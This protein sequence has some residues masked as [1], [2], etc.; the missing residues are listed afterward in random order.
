[1]KRLRIVTGRN[2]TRKWL[3][4]LTAQFQEYPEDSQAENRSSDLGNNSLPP[5]Y[6][7][8]SPE[9]EELSL[10]LILTPPQTNDE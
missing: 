10:L 3:S 9:V 1:M 5:P 8:R 2:N 4:L 6:S 7:V